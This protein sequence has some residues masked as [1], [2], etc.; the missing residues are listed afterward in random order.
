MLGVEFD[1]AVL[2]GRTGADMTTACRDAGL[3]LIGATPTAVRIAPPITTEPAQL[4]E[5]V[6]IIAAVLA[7][8]GGSA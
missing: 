6:E 5:A 1:P 8:G 3:L 4:D 7:S 2:A